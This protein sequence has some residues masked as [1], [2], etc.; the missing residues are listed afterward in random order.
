M[1]Y[2]RYKQ[3]QRLT[4]FGY[5][6]ILKTTES[7]TKTSKQTIAN[8]VNVDTKTLRFNVNK[9]SSI[10]LSQYAKLVVESLSCPLLTEGGHERN[11]PITI[12][13]NNLNTHAYD[14]ENNGF[15][16]TLIYISEGQT[17]VTRTPFIN[18]S[19]EMLYNFSIDQHFFKN[20]Y[21]ELQI[22]YPDV[23]LTIDA[24]NRFYISF[25]V[26]DVDEED[27][28]LKDTPEVD[29]KNWRAHYNLNNGRI[30]K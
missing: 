17:A 1:K 4:F 29:F 8:G 16:N 20:G 21:I 6:D 10:Q 23:P 7:L 27:L 5:D 9:I 25:V 11:G 28:L 19:P 24:L 30:P 22:T 13:M 26:Y 2:Y 15:S 12:R 14:S 3:L 18:P